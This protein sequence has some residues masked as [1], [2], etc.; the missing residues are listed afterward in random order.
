M[1]RR[2]GPSGVKRA[3]KVMCSL[4]RRSSVVCD[5]RPSEAKQWTA[6]GE[7]GNPG[8]IFNDT[9]HWCDVRWWGIK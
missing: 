5:E 2:E 8:C 7:E 6:G 4:G 9:L 1:A 3:F